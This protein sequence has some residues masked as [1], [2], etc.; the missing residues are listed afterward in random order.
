MRIRAAVVVVVVLC[1]P[2]AAEAQTAWDTPSSQGYDLVPRTGAAL[3]A[4]FWG[5]ENAGAGLFGMSGLLRA[6]L[7]LDRVY[8]LS[9]DAGF[10][11]GS[12]NPVIDSTF[13]GSTTGNHG[14]SANPRFSLR[15]IVGERRWRLRVGGGVSIPA[16]PPSPQARET[17][18]LGSLMHGYSE[19][20][21]WSASRASIIVDGEL[22]AVPEDYLYLEARAAIGTLLSTSENSFAPDQGARFADV[23]IDLSGAIGVRHDNFL[24]GV[25]FRQTFLPTFDVDQAQSSVELFLRPTGRLEGT[26]IELFGELRASANLDEPFGLTSQLPMWGVYASFGIGTT[27]IEIPDGRFGIRSVDFHGVEQLDDRAI[28]ACLGTRARSRFGVDIGIRGTPE[29][30]EAPFDGDHIVLDLFSYPWST[31]PLFD[32]NVFERD[33]ERIER[34]YRARGYYDARVTST[35][36]T[37]PEATQ[38]DL[39]VEDCG[40]GHGNCTAH[41]EFGIDEGEPVRV[42]RISIRGIDDLPEGMKSDLRDRLGFRRDDP[43]DEALLETT[44]QRML[45]VLADASYGQARVRADVK[46]NT[47][48]HEAFIVF[49]VDAGLPNVINRICITGFGELPPELMLGVTYLDPGDRFRLD[50]MEEAQRA[51]YGLGTFSAVEIAPVTRAE[52][53]EAESG[54]ADPIPADA[55]CSEPLDVVPEGTHPV[56][57]LIRVTPGRRYRIG[58]GG[59]FQAGQAVTVG[60]STGFGSGQQNAAQWDLHLSFF[61]EDRNFT[62]NL[63]RARFEVRPR[64]I[65]DMPILP[66][67]PAEPIPFGVLVN[68]SLRAP[69]VFEPRT[70]LVIE[71]RLDLG[72]MPFTNFFRF[73]PDGVVGLD[74]TWEDGRIYAA[75]FAHGNAFLPTDRQPP[76]PNDELSFTYANYLEA[77]GRVDLRD[78]PRNPHLG[79]YFEAG[80]QGSVQPLSTWSFLRWNA[81]ARG[82][83]PLG[84]LFTVAVRFQIGAMHIFG[85]DESQLDS[86]NRYRLHQLGPPALQL[87]AGGASSN[88]G[89]LPG[90][91]GDAEDV[92]VTEPQTDEEIRRGAPVEQRSVRISGGTAMWQASFELRVRLTVDLGVVGFV[93]AGDVL[94]PEDP[95]TTDFVGFRFDRPQLSFGLGLRYRTIIG[96]LRVDFALRPD[97][98]QDLGSERTLPIDCRPDRAE[99]CRPRNTLFGISELPGAVHLTIG[100]SF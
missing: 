19:L 11:Y 100:E 15:G 39:E 79:A 73:E 69:G 65:F 13:L 7:V 71:T 32:E 68:G 96:P 88:R 18:L 37:P 45:R 57:I 8:E 81:D 3:E 89:Y 49:E 22:V 54:E 30:G 20:W 48:R 77:N 50:E 66:P 84:D 82:Y 52:E 16:I 25:R 55:H 83:V 14:A 46:V 95:T 41:V 33:I 23:A 92:Y 38:V 47:R 31:W 67:V 76:D 58:V 80:V 63:V 70:N 56:D 28:A 94:R 78:D 42:A 27:P 87:R 10:M 59:G 24:G 62:E 1:A 51:L 60:T 35:E 91:L 2:A 86:N 40:D 93:D 97:D 75:V 5:S 98:L 61:A 90:L 34:W 43:F 72:P 21:L 17:A 85:Y 64:A 26:S 12:L 99:N 4:G 53:R 44:K 74:H 36:V 29:C 9:I 6:G